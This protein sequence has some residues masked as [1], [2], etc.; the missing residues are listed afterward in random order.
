MAAGMTNFKREL[1]SPRPKHVPTYCP[2]EFSP[3]GAHL[4]LILFSISGDGPEVPLGVAQLAEEQMA[5]ITRR[6][7]GSLS[8]GKF[9]R[10]RFVVHTKL[11]FKYLRILSCLC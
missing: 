3:L 10:R 5:A 6:C 1:S 11:F 8:S 2:S 7:I 9:V 4:E